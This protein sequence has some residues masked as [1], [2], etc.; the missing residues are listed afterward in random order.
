MVVHGALDHA[1]LAHWG[2]SAEALIDFSSN[3]NPFGPPAGVRAAL[4]ALD[5]APYPDRSCYHLRTSLALRHSCAPTQILVGNGANELIH[6][7]ARALL[8]FGDTVLVIGPTFGE[9]THAS[10]LAGAVVEEWRASEEAHFNLHIDAIQHQIKALRPRL[11]WLCVPNNPTG[12][13]LTPAQIATLCECCVAHGGMLVVDRAYAGFIQATYPIREPLDHALPGLLRLYSLTKSYAIAGLRLGYLIGTEG[14]I[15]QVARF[16]PT[17]SVS[18]AALAAGAAALTD[19]DFLP[20]TMSQ[21]WA[22]SDQL[23]HGLTALGFAVHR[24]ALPFM[25]VRSGDATATR[26]A[27]LR[28]GCAVRDATSFGL[29]AWVRIAPRHPDENQTLLRVWKEILC[30]P[31]S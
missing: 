13:D 3:L 2:I 14:V 7:I 1:E 18:S 15:H 25:L 22:S 31:Q 8:T 12:L 5:P 10:Q 17:W 16:Q 29:P 6:L 30:P 19:S 27:L 26:M 9:Y 24:A 28:R 23:Y 4:A 20:T 21:L 11:T